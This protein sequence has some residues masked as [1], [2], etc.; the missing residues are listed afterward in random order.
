MG[1]FA[2]S[3]DNMVD[4]LVRM[5]TPQLSSPTNVTCTGVLALLLYRLLG[6]VSRE[7]LLM[8]REL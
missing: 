6:S 8:S 1:S 5:G 3:F 4:E 2:G 7:S